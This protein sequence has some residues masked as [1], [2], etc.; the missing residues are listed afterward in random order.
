MI[1]KCGKD[2]LKLTG[3]FVNG[4]VEYTCEFCGPNEKSFTNVLGC[5]NFNAH[6]DLQLD[7]FFESKEH[8]ANYLKQKGLTQ[9]SGTNSPKQ[10]EGVGRTVCT[11]GQYQACKRKGVL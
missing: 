1:C 6:Y 11:K 4:S 8:K 7:T 2:V 10:T 5:D 3:R 9:V